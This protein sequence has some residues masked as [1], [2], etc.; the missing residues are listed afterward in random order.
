[1]WT[2]NSTFRPKSGAVAFFLSILIWGIGVGSFMAA[3]NN[4]LYD[5]HGVDRQARG[6]IEFFREMPGV[7]LVV[8]LA[9]LHKVSDWRIMRIGTLISLVGVTALCFPADKV[10]V[11]LFIVTWSLGEH[12]VMPV[13]SS[14]AMQVAQEGKI[15]VSLGFM[16]S[17][18]NC[19]SVLGSMLVAALF[20]AGQKWLS[21]VDKVLL[22]NCV[23]GTIAVLMVL[24]FVMTFTKN[25][26]MG[27]SNRPRMYFSSRYN[28]FYILELFYGARKQI[29]LTFAPYVMIILYGF[30]TEQVALMLGVSCTLNIF[31]GPVIGRICDRIGYR[32]VM[33]Y[34]TVVLFFVCLLYGFAHNWFVMSVAVWI[35]TV[36]YM[37]DG[38]ISQTTMAGSM[39]VKALGGTKDEVTSTLSTGISINHVISIIA[40]WAG[41]WV[42]EVW[43]VQWLFVFAC[44]MCIANTLCAMTIPRIPVAA[45]ETK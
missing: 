45:S 12:L 23:W 26:P 34:D 13:R 16:N 15:G 42:W 29:F 18:S 38:I 11:T 25:A 5:I 27:V 30:S 4:F 43:G 41:G 17:V 32:N 19:G 2:F 8:F 36:N 10:M 44:I 39:Y 24:S 1:M 20:Y 22:Y 40:A 33:I 9:I 3:I 37:L 21:E 7:F 6:I 31:F 14:I 28:R 35:V